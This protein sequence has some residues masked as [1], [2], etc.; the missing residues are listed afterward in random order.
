MRGVGRLIF[1]FVVCGLLVLGSRAGIAVTPAVKG[2]GAPE[3][4]RTDDLVRP[5]GIDDPT[6][7]FS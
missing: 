4:L 6:P 7:R 2:P 3:K 1:S 5:L